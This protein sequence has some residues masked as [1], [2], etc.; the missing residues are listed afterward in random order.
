MIVIIWR[1]AR[2][3]IRIVCFPFSYVTDVGNPP[4]PPLFFFSPFFL[5][6]S[7]T[8]LNRKHGLSQVSP[9]QGLPPPRVE[10]TLM[11]KLH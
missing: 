8:L 2:D 7:V 6:S 10:G 3:V 5:F 9:R 1:F 4:P 11:F